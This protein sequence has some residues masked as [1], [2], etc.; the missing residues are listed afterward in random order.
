MARNNIHNST[1]HGSWSD[2]SV[3]SQ[4]HDV[5]KNNKLDDDYLKMNQEDETTT[6]PK[7]M[8]HYG[9]LAGVCFGCNNY[10]TTKVSSL[11]L[12]SLFIFSIGAILLC[13][14]YKVYY[15][16][17]TKKQTGHYWQAEDSNLLR[18]N[19]QGKVRPNISNCL[20]LTFRTAL[21]IVQLYCIIKSF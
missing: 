12:D 4:E 20:G 7:F 9:L 21:A 15:M 18:I 16:L 1:K 13:S 2:F 17:Q 6:E 14:L 8:P 5:E 3:V 10:C 11:G 19:A